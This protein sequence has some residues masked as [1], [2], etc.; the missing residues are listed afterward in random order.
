MSSSNPSGLLEG[1]SLLGVLVSEVDNDGLR[2]GGV[3]VLASIRGGVDRGDGVL[4][5]SGLSALQKSSSAW[6]ARLRDSGGHGSKSL[7]VPD[8]VSLRGSRWAE[9]EFEWTCDDVEGRG[10]GCGY[11]P[12][13]GWATGKFVAEDV[14]LPSG[15][16][17]AVGW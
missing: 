9:N 2:I 6:L 8:T 11:D 7:L 5:R 4:L 13:S 12:W 10:W 3:R 16:S 1:E 14:G 15:V 17:S